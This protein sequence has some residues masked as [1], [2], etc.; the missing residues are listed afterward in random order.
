MESRQ[1]QSV[2]AFEDLSRDEFDNRMK[3]SYQL[4]PE[5]KDKDKAKENEKLRMIFNPI[6][7]IK[8]DEHRA[9]LDTTDQASLPSQI[10]KVIRDGKENQEIGVVSLPVKDRDTRI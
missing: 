10:E 6:R 7:Y 3:N 5:V 8:P 9:Q 4:Y 1:L 2:Q